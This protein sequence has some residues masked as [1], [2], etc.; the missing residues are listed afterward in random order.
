MTTSVHQTIDT[1]YNADST[2]W[3]PVDGFQDLLLCGTYQLEENESDKVKY[4]PY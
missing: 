2:E 3:C 1:V 4:I